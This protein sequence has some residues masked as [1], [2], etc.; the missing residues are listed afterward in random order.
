MSHA[1]IKRQYTEIG[2]IFHSVFTAVVA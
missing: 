2:V 1:H